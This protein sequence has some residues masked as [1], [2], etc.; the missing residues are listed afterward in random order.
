MSGPWC[1]HDTVARASHL[2]GLPP[3]CDA[4]TT[5][6]A[7]R[8]LGVRRDGVPCTAAAPLAFVARHHDPDQP[9]G[10]GGHGC[11]RC[12]AAHRRSHPEVRGSPRLRR[13]GLLHPARTGDRPT[14]R[15]HIG[16]ARDRPRQR[17]TEVRLHPSDRS[18]QL[19]GGHPQD[20]RERG[21]QSG[22]GPTAGSFE[23]PRG[24]GLVHAPT[25]RGGAAREHHQRPVLQSVASVGRQRCHRGLRLHPRARRWPFGWSGFEAT[26]FDFP[27]GAAPDYLLW[28]SPAFTR[29][30][31]PRV[32]ASYLYF[33]RLRHGAADLPRFDAAAS[34]LGPSSIFVQNV[35][36]PGRI[37][38]GV[39]A[40]PGDRLVAAGSAGRPRRARGRR[41]GIGASEHRRERGIPD[42][43]RT[44]PGA[45]A[46]GHAGQRTQSGGGARGCRG[47]RGH[48]H[49]ALPDRPAG[50]GACRRDFDRDHLRCARPD[51][52]RARDGRNCGRAR[53]LA[54]PAG[55]SD[56]TRQQPD[57]RCEALE[58]AR[59]SGIDGRTAKHGDRCPQRA[60]AEERRSQRAGGQCAARHGVGGGG[61]LRDGGVRRQPHAPHRHAE[62]VRRSLPAQHFEPERRDARPDCIAEPRARPGSHR[63]HAGDRASRHHDRQGRGR[64]PGRNGR[65]G[66]APHV[67]G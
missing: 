27:S 1:Q 57:R 14:A 56:R 2:G 23:P 24:R 60:R 35:G 25:R 43:G 16:H 52:R 19:R 33:V 64:G 54:C 36:R 51:A 12:R 65:P 7:R 62:A 22:V 34:A 37:G 10:R 42:V 8:V 28:A 32:G 21:L 45:P 11:R 17:P 38:R 67:H 41:A 9:G 31:L 46:V 15:G 48:R 61:A 26:E 59:S 55:K 40:P 44:R 6:G 20:R 13:R 3:F 39:G 63:P 53:H 58:A 29:E 47:R 18:V 66:I 30:V 50:R 5:I 4:G 49:P